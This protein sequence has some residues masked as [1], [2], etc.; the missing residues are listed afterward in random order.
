MCLVR[1]I[2][3]LL[4]QTVIHELATI[5]ENTLK[6]EASNFKN[7]LLVLDRSID[8]RYTAQLAVIVHGVDKDF[9]ISKEMVELVP[10]RHHKSK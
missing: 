10:L 6:L 2:N 7:Y 1:K 5:V 8:V 9:N 3:I 4:Q